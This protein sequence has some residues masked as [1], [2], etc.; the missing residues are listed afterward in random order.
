M[1]LN[2]ER[3]N[4]ELSEDECRNCQLAYCANCLVYVNGATARPLCIQCAL[5]HSGIRGS[6]RVKPT[7]RDRRTRAKVTKMATKA[8]AVAE[9][10]AAEV[11]AREA[12][13]T[14]V[15]LDLAGQRTWASLDASQWDTGPA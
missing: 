11:A 2:C 15:D 1:I 13:A 4:W 9:R 10:E 12:A 8:K 6:K 7:R 3:H 14:E 5:K